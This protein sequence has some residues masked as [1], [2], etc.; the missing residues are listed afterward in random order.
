M[1]RIVPEDSLDRVLW[2]DMQAQPAPGAVPLLAHYT[3]IA[4]LER[5][6]QTGEIW[7]SNPLYMNDVDELRYGMSLGL[8][9]VRTHAGLR[10]ACPP[11]Q[12]NALLDAFDTLF[13]AFDNESAFDVY[14]FS[15]SEHDETIGDDGLL[16][17]WRGYG[18]DGNGVAIVFDMSQ[19]LAARSPLLVHQ[20]QYLSYE[21]SE[22]WMAHKLQRFAL[23]LQQ[24]GGSVADMAPAAAA[25]FER[26]K[27]FALF[28]KHRGFHEEREWR[29]VYL[30]EHDRGDR[31]TQQLHYAIS[32]R[33][34]EPR[35]RFSTDALSD[36]EHKPSLEQMV[37][38]IILGPVLATPLAL[39]SVAR[40]LELYQPAWAT[41]VARSTTPYRSQRTWPTT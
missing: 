22:G 16:S 33:G 24:Q 4:T 31:F 36:G 19:L 12:Y 29:I 20:V 14:V 25:L 34:I 30:R 26:I 10:Q 2:S 7:F 39:R 5:I 8:H 3:S 41:R 13:T 38:R 15:C 1:H 40:M 28:T 17:M 21:A 11:A 27:L 9:A 23:A 32:S 6:A 37:Q 18:G 35:L